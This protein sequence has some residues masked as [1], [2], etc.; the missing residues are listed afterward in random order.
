MTP[1][2]IDLNARKREL[3]MMR[4]KRGSAAAAPAPATQPLPKADRASALPLSF[5]Q[6]RLWFLDQLDSAASVAYNLPGALRLSGRLD[7]AALQAALDRIVARHE[8]LRTTFVN[9]DGDPVQRIG[10]P[11]SAFPFE[12]Q[13]LGE[14]TGARQEE[15]LARLCAAEVARPFSLSDGPLV[16]A[17]LLRLRDDEHILLV[18]QHHIISDGWSIGVMVRELSALYG[19]FVQGLPDPLP[20]LS[21]QYADYAAWQRT[22]LQGEVLRAQVDF[23]K[24]HLTGAPALLAVPTDRPR[25]AVQGYA[26]ASLALSLPAHLTAGLRALSARHGATLFMTMMAGWTA[27]LARMSGQQDVVVGT[28]VANRQRTEMEAMIGFFVNTLALRVQMADDPTVAQLLAQVKASMLGAYQHQDLPFEQIVEL[29]QPARSM[30]YSPVFQVML[31]MSNTPGGGALVLP[32]LTL[33]AVEQTNTTT[34]FDLSLMLTDAGDH[35]VGNLSYATALF[36]A[37]S[38]ERLLTHFQVLLEGMVAHEG[39][40]LGELPLL[41]ME[42]RNCVLAQFNDTAAAMPYHHLIHQLFEVQAA[43]RP[44]AIA[45][46]FEGQDL[47]YADLNGQAN[48]VAHALLAM[49]VKPNERV[50]ICVERGPRMLAGLLGIMKAGAGYVPLDPGFPAERLAYMLSDCA[51][52]AL[53]SEAALLDDA[54]LAKALQAPGVARL[55]LDRDALGHLPL[56]NPEV[57]GL[58]GNSLAY[59][60]YT[61]GSTGLP[62]GVMVEHGSVA[63]FLASMSRAPGIAAHDALLAVTTL[64]FDIA[65]LELYLPLMNG[66]R[67]VLASRAT[68]SDASLL[69]RE[70]ATSGATIMQATPATWRMLLAGGWSGAPGLKILCGGEALPADLAARLLGCARALWNVYGPTETTI[71]STCRQV[72]DMA[73][74]IGRPIANTQVYILD[75]RLQPVPLGASGEIHI[76]G[77]GVARGYLNRPELTAERFL[78]DPFAGAPDARM[79]KTGDVGRWLANGEIEYQGRNDFQVKVRGFRIELGEIEARLAACAGVREAVVMA[80]ADN[81]AD[82]ADLR[83]VAYLLAQEGCTLEAATL[84]AALLEHLADYMVPSAYVMLDAFP[85]TPNNKIDRK[86]LPAPDQGAVIQRAY[87]APEGAAEAAIAAVW[88][89]LL[90][91]AQVGRDDNFFELGGHS[92]MIVKMVASLRERGVHTNLRQVFGAPTV[93][94]LARVSDGGVAAP[95]PSLAPPNLIGAGCTHITP[96]MLPLVK[97]SQVEI[98]TACATVALGVANVQDIYPLAPLQGGILFHHLTGEGADP[99]LM[100]SVMSFASA[101]ELERFLD[102]LQRVIDRHDIL[103]SAV[104]WKGLGTPVQLV[105]RKAVMEREVVAVQGGAQALDALLAHADPLRYTMDLQ[106]APLLAACVALDAASGEWHLALMHHHLVCDHVTLGFI[107]AE[108]MAFLQG[109]GE[110]LPAPQPYRN[111]VAHALGADSSAH[112]AYFRALLADIDAP[113]AP[114]G[115]P[116][117]GGAGRESSARLE[118]DRELGERVRDSA[119][120]HGVTPA[121]LFHAAWAQVAGQCSGRDDVVF[122]TVLS[123]RMQGGEAGQILGM[124]VNTLPLRFSLANASA[125]DVVTEAHRQLG[126]LMVHEH[127]SLALAQ[128]C[129]AVAAPAPLFTSL[130]NYRNGGG[131]ADAAPVGESQAMLGMRSHSA[132]ERAN[133]PLTVSVDEVGQRFSI[134]AQCVGVDPARVAGMLARA[135]DALLVALEMPADQ[136]MQ[137]LAVVSE[138]E[139]KQLAR[140]NDTAAPY[141]HDGLIHQV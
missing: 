97:L 103:R 10:A 94:A 54:A 19:A 124:F 76:G 55:L 140:F 74:S 129:S 49:G 60:I 82:P 83:L 21:L 118:L 91:V 15:A 56:S 46:S 135:L 42:Q 104:L 114:F 12:Q 38:M 139:L 41:S 93:A 47:S 122:G 117:T 28:P 115:L 109:Q 16:R 121:V 8:N 24:S 34:Q 77:A 14:L 73:E 86:A 101:I 58:D 70:I 35:I 44:D 18:T 17:R 68:A 84:R 3:L 81:A 9:V 132:E 61:S 52:A 39:A 138:A 7:K 5:A 23:W 62:K 59:V 99:Y 29:L 72:T 37:G 40:R 4:L 20:P 137:T 11:D 125:R 26:G 113:T 136:A 79:Y 130:L 128:R 25:P 119:R 102:A 110:A 36:D 131:D 6:Q 71:W 120:R 2:T 64:S 105:Y 92:L 133:Y 85:L 30:S 95:A 50:A 111:F 1:S 88:Q 51:P 116:A 141:P 27:L 107:S 126:E 32:G 13:D 22:W 106:R 48:R 65:G 96:Q 100:R 108:I 123:G 66:A 75:S 127:A 69:A 63:N 78:A 90:G 80:R 53:L 87:A 98:D 45:L 43:R 112:Q 33:G 89:D 134:A 31:S 67:I 57:P